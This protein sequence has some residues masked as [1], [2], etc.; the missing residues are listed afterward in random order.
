MSTLLKLVSPGK[1]KFLISLISAIIKLTMLLTGTIGE[2]RQLPSLSMAKTPE[3]RLG[4]ACPVELNYRPQCICDFWP[5]ETYNAYCNASSTQELNVITQTF[6][7]TP[8]VDHFEVKITLTGSKMSI[9][10]NMLSNKTAASI[11]IEC[12]GDEAELGPIDPQAF[13]SSA[14]K[15]SAFEIAFCDLTNFDF[16]FLAQLRVLATLRLRNTSVTTMARMPLMPHLRTIELYAPN[17]FREWHDPAQTPWLDTIIINAA[18]GTDEATMEQITDT[19]VYYQWSLIRLY[20]VN[21][22]LTRVP[23]VVRNMTNLN[24]LDLSENQITTL[25]SGSLALMSSVSSLWLHN[26]PL[27][28][29]EPEAFQGIGKL[30]PKFT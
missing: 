5:Y 22:G 20:L 16:A 21:L 6:E 18:T 11:I 24:T 17:G 14:G 8:I 29:I 23:P 13:I 15:T 12:K 28:M 4:L 30:Y 19:L 2:S 3:E 7:Q 9:P 10:A 26:M 25:P 27:Q 1:C